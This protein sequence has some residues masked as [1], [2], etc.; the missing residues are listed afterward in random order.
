MYCRLWVRF[1]SFMRPDIFQ[2]FAI[3]IINHPV[4][5][6]MSES[7][8]CC[9]SSNSTGRNLAPFVDNRMVPNLYYQDSSLRVLQFWLAHP[10]R[11]ATH[12]MLY[13]SSAALRRVQAVC[14][15]KQF[16]ERPVAPK[17]PDRCG[18]FKKFNITVRKQRLEDTLLF[19]PSPGS[20]HWP[21]HSTPDPCLGREAP[22]S[23]QLLQHGGHIHQAELTAKVADNGS[24]VQHQDLAGRLGLTVLPQVD[25]L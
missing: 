16:Q 6:P 4:L 17:V 18:F 2:L 15:H 24:V 20:V 8:H 13:V 14:V 21:P 19:P 1:C 23:V 22:C 5:W 10:P 12:A 25:C 3:E 7:A 9:L 11:F